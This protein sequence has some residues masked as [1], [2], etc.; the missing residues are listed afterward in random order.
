MCFLEMVWVEHLFQRGDRTIV[1]VAPAIPDAFQ[2]RNF[3][4]ARG[5]SSLQ[6]QAGVRADGDWQNIEGRRLVCRWREALGERQFITRVERRRMAAATAFAYKDFL[7]RL[8][9]PI[10]RM[11]IGGWL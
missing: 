9:L 3:V 10:K 4:I 6:S 8:R 5:L 1:K 7:A 2:R 11:E